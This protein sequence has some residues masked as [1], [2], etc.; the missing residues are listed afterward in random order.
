[1]HAGLESPAGL[2]QRSRHQR[3]RVLE[4]LEE[5]ED[6]IGEVGRRTATE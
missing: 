3:S 2:S 1:M 5:A 4:K 6:G